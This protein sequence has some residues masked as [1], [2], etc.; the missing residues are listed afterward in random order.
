VTEWNQFRQ[1]DFARIKE[2]MRGNVFVDCRNVYTPGL[3]AGKGFV[4]ESFGRGSAQ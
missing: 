1:L 2:S 3:M 4:Y